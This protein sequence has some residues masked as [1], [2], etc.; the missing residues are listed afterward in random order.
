MRHIRGDNTLQ[1]SGIISCVGQQVDCFQEQQGEG[2]IEGKLSKGK[3]Y[4]NGNGKC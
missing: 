2:K 1:Q 3:G 4:A